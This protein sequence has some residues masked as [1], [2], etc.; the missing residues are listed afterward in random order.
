MKAIVVLLLVAGIAFVIRGALLAGRPLSIPRLD[1][2]S[3]PVLA[4]GGLGI[5]ALV[6]VPLL[7]GAGDNPAGKSGTPGEAFV[8]SATV[9]IDLPELGEGVDSETGDLAQGEPTAGE[10]LGS[11]VAPE[12]SEPAGSVGYG[13]GGS[14]G[15]LYEDDEEDSKQRPRKHKDDK[16]KDDVGDDSANEPDEPDEKDELDEKD[17]DEEDGSEPE[18]DEDGED[19]DS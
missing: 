12:D 6:A 2:I 18:D 7:S 14:S 16:P 4:T 5:A 11:E 17:K 10:S 15:E 1:R 9:D 3:R 19:D 8:A 13:T